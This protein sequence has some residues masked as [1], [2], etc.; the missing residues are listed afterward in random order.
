MKWQQQGLE[1]VTEWRK[2]VGNT[3]LVAIGGVTPDR[4]REAFAAGADIAS[5]VTDITLNPDPESRIREWLQ[6]TG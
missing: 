5:A 4:A 1:R 2:L 3:P 6:V